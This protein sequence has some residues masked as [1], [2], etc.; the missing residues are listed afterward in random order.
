MVLHIGAWVRECRRAAGL[1]QAQLGEALGKT[2][3]NISAWE[4]N[5]H[6]PSYAQMLL[7]AESCNWKVKLPGLPSS[8][9]S[10]WP[11][12]TISEERYN[13]ASD[14]LKVAIEEAI[15]RQ[16]RAFDEPPEPVP[17]VR[18]KSRARRA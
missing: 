16:L 4:A 10:Q 12:R 3:A 8:T 15:D 2:K 6:E 9:S 13:A 14:A 18:S 7:I 5:R 17:E 11:F 1:T